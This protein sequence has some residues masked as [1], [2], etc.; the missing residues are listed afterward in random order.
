MCNYLKNSDMPYLKITCS[1]KY[2]PDFSSIAER[3][4]AEIN[5]LFF[6]PNAR[7]SR[8]ELRQRTTIHFVPYDDNEL[9]IGG[10]TIADRQTVDI[11]AELSDWSMSDRQK[12]KVAKGLTPVLAELFH[13]PASEIDNINIR[14][15]SYPPTDFSVGGK[16][17]ADIIP[18]IGRLAKK[19]IS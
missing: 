17:L 14:F 6:N 15:H 7:L 12:R 11:T 18:L 2:K 19:L 5:N 8:E 10:Q 13:V 16:L 9:F 3:L 4:T 1:D